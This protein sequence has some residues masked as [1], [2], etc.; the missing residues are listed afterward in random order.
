MNSDALAC[1]GRDDLF[2][3]DDDNYDTPNTNIA[4]MLCARCPIRLECRMKG[5]KEDWGIWGGLTPDERKRA[6][7]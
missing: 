5:D 6:R 7:L 2:F 4:R 3:P 1:E